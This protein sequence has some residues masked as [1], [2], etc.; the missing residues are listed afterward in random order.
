MPDPQLPLILRTRLLNIVIYYQRNGYLSKRFCLLMKGAVKMSI[1]KKWLKV[2]SMVLVVSMLIGI[3]WVPASADDPVPTAENGDGSGMTQI[4]GTEGSEGQSVGG[5]SS[6]DEITPPADTLSNDT[7]TDDPTNEVADGSNIGIGETSRDNAEPAK[8]NDQQNPEDSEEGAFDEKST[9]PKGNEPSGDQGGQLTSTPESSY[10]PTMNGPEIFEETAPTPTPDV[11]IAD[12]VPTESVTSPIEENLPSEVGNDPDLAMNGGDVTERPSTGETSFLPNYIEAVN[13]FNEVKFSMD[14]LDTI[15][16][17]REIV[18]NTE[19][20]LVDEE[21]RLADYTAIKAEYN[22]RN[23]VWIFLGEAKEIAAFGEMTLVTVYDLFE[24]VYNADKVLILNISKPHGSGTYENDPAVVEAIG[25]MNKGKARVDLAN[26]AM[27]IL[28]VEDPRNVPEEKIEELAGYEQNF[29]SGFPDS[30]FLAELE[31]L[32]PDAVE[33]YDTLHDEILIDAYEAVVAN[34]PENCDG[35]D[36]KE[37]EELINEYEEAVKALEDAGV[38]DALTDDGEKKYQSLCSYLKLQQE[39]TDIGSVTLESIAETGGTL[40]TGTFDCSSITVKNTIKITGEVT[41]AGGNITREADITIFE[42]LSGGSLTLNNVTLSG[43]T[44][45]KI[46]NKNSP[47]VVSNGGKLTLNGTKIT[48]FIGQC[49]GGVFTSGK[50]VLNSGSAIDEN[51]VESD[52]R[53]I[54]VVGGGVYIDNGGYVEMNPGSSV[55]NN[56]AT[57]K[58]TYDQIAVGGGIAI[59]AGGAFTMNGG[60]ISGNKVKGCPAVCEGGGIAIGSD[61]R[62]SFEGLGSPNGELIKLKAG[63]ISNNE[64]WRGA[65][66]YIHYGTVLNLKNVA[67]TNNSAYHKQYPG[68]WTRLFKHVPGF[69]T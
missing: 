52:K 45:E 2:L 38:Q 40:S 33:R 48:K 42:V 13:A 7:E 61:S 44:T 27:E 39:G 24:H 62:P 21:R 51:T 6:E 15:A 29:R 56:K 17:L 30:D 63:E 59:K 58:D 57:V 26:Y 10:A 46:G 31:K 8:R 19:L 68:S 47:V 60:T 18:E 55:S 28:A 66:V 36:V 5:T 22:D 32:S 67:I 11:P 53:Q 1:G 41:V 54:P 43:G 14:N 3:L 16:E 35:L 20:K 64:A 34:L 37:A 50:L 69:W 23:Y 12:P 9:E 65:G 25:I 4:A 49:G